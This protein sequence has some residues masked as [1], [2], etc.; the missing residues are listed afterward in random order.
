MTAIDTHGSNTMMRTCLT[1]LLAAAM[2]AACGGGEAPAGPA[3]TERPANLGG[4]DIT[5]QNLMDW[6]ELAYPQYFYP[7]RPSDKIALPYIYRFYEETANY[8]GLD[9]DRIYVM[10]RDFGSTPLFV[11]RVA[12]FACD[13]RIVFCVAPAIAVGPTSRLALHGRQTEFEVATTGGPSI[14]YQWMRDSRPI[15]GANARIYKIDSVQASDDGAR[16]SVWVSNAKGSAQSNA[17]IVTYVARVSV[18]SFTTLAQSKGCTQ[19]HAVDST[20]TGPPWRAVAERYTTR[21]DAQVYIAQ[22]I[23]RGSTNV[24]GGNM[25]P[26]AVTQSEAE[27]LAAGI[28]SLL[29]N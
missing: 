2:L 12:D 15:P 18:A 6:A 26:N 22:R 8:L 28:L 5:A 21:S 3:P 23:L 11:G 9:D 17:A 13:V 10:G 20:V 14:R 4:T 24:W 7:A 29:P 16:I 19:C 25:Q 27:L 1:S